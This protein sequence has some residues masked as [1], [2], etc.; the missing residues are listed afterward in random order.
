MSVA[1]GNTVLLQNLDEEIDS[2]LEPLLNKT[3]KK[4]ADRYMLYFGDKEIRYHES[5]RFFMT[6]KLPNPK[7]KPEVT[8]KVIL[9]NFTVKEKGLEEQLTSVV[10]GKM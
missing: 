5:F 1:N 6:T 9:V 4:V 3:I 8:T 10:I 7:Y 2:S